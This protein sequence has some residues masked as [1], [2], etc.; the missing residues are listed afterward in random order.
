MEATD[1]TRRT[2]FGAFDV[3][4]RS[5]EVH[6]HGI[7]LKL[8]DQPFQVLSLLL[9]H[10]GDV[11]TREELRRKL[12]P[13]DTFVDFD[14]GLNS[15]IKKLRLVLGDSAEHPRF[16]ETLPRRGYRWLAP[17]EC[18]RDIASVQVAPP[19]NETVP[20]SKV[21][22]R[23]AAALSGI[24]FLCVLALTFFAL[25][26]GKL[27]TRLLSRAVPVRIQSVAVLPLENLSHEPEQ[28]YFADG[29]TEELI[30]SLGKIGRASSCR[31]TT[32]K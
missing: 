9:E 14:N 1:R 3:D 24:A 29:M 20:A 2:R 7:R 19:A 6:K 25:D 21:R 17:V 27:R 18:D 5:G 30:K 12:W 23:Y 26:V 4:L 32:D 8:Q 22:L 28:E 31:P 13:G 10:E 15:A 16:I 11:V